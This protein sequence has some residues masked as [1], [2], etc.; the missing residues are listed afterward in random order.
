MG[1]V[2]AEE[3]RA[4]VVRLHAEGLGRN[5]IARTVGCSVGTVTKICQAEGLS[6]ERTLTLA[7]RCA[8]VDN[9]TRRASILAKLYAEADAKLDELAAVREGRTSWRALARGEMGVEDTKRLDYVPARDYA[10]VSQSVGHLAAH[11]AKLEAVDSPTTAA[12]TSLL[13]GLA[14]RLGI[15]DRPQPQPPAD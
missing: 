9:A 7:T 1:E 6:F 12:A 4:E 11:A 10:F 13:A 14:E 2:K 5:T 15:D 8:Q 3:A